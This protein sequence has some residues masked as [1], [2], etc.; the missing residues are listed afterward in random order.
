MFK[1]QCYTNVSL[2]MVYNNQWENAVHGQACFVLPGS[3][4][5]LSQEPEECHRSKSCW[6]NYEF[7]ILVKVIHILKSEDT[8]LSNFV[9]MKIIY[10]KG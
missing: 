5:S 1:K 10:R 8:L 9:N 7:S 4:P 2:E 3:G 6:K